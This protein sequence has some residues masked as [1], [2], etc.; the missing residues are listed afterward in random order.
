MM[1]GLGL[2][3]GGIEGQRRA[4]GLFKVSVAKA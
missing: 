4:Y 3:E 2:N 1:D